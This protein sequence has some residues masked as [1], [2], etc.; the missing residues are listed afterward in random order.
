M[1]ATIASF[2]SSYDRKSKL[3][4]FDQTK[5]DIK[6]LVDAGIRKIPPIFF[7]PWDTTPKI[8]TT[9][10]KI[11]VIDLQSTHRASMVEMIREASTNLEALG[12]N[13]NHLGD[14]DCGKG[15]LF[16]GHY[17]PA[18]P[19]PELTIGT[20][21]HTDDRFLVVLL[22]EQTEGL[23]IRHQ[24]PKSKYVLEYSKEINSLLGNR[25][26]SPSLLIEDPKTVLKIDE[27]PSSLKA[28]WELLV[29]DP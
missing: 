12:L 17:Y 29:L 24:N 18:C 20:S 3:K 8:S 23:K 27:E 11:L 28:A 6:G 13:V 19:Q 16:S 5:T 4:A 21:N 26:S 10:V 1:A 14:L 25:K 7:H 15:L 2:G 9:V 22:Q